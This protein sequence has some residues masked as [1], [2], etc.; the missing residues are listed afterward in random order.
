MVMTPVHRSDTAGH[1]EPLAERILAAALEMAEERG[2]EAV[3]LTEVAARLDIPARSVLDHYRDLDAV[4]NAWFMRGW[5]AMLADKPEDFDDR[6]SRERIEFCMLAWFD[7]LASHRRVTV[8][9]LRTKAHWPHL[10]TWVPMLFDLSRTIQWL[11]EAARLDASYGTRRAQMEEIGLTA[12]FVAT[13]RI[14]AHDDT[15]NQQDTRHY[16]RKRL[17]RSER[18]MRRVWGG[19]SGSRHE[20][21]TPD[22]ASPVITDE[23]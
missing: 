17:E 21:A 15:P 13:L 20:G 14:W 2:W 1:Y 16:L 4:A 9:M 22:R 3:E 10:H 19:R 18:L 23:P 12:L 5:R 6:P 11:R 7:A 8:Q